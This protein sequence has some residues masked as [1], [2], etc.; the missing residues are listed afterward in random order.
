MKAVV[1]EKAH[2]LDAWAI[3]LADVAEPTPG[4][5]D[6]LVEVH[7]VGINP[8][9][10][11]FRKTRSADAGGRVLLGWGFAGGGV[12]IG[13]GVRRFTV[14]DRVF[15]TGDMRRDGAWAERVAVDHRILAT[16]PDQL[17]FADAASLP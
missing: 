11:F 7:A 3:E 14:G 8:G 1:Y 6:V 13:S 5:S 16:F 4:G 2:T 15:G 10:T 9:E 17:S 12:G